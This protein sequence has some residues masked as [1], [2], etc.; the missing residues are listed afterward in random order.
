MTRPGRLIRRKRFG[1]AASFVMPVDE[2]ASLPIHVGRNPEEL[3]LGLIEANGLEGEIVHP[4]K[5]RLFQPFP[6]GDIAVGFSLLRRALVRREADFR[7]FSSD[8]SLL[9]AEGYAIPL[10]HGPLF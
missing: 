3:V 2:L 7:P 9:V 6:D 1:L 4:G 10:L 5:E 8:A